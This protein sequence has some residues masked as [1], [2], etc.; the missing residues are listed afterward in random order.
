[1]MKLFQFAI[2]IGSAL[3][4]VGCSDGSQQY[5]DLDNYMAEMKAKPV[6]VIKPLPE[7][8]RYEA[9]TYEASAMRSPFRQPVRIELTP[10]QKNSNLKPDPYRAKQ[11]L[12]QFEMDSFRLV[13]SI[14][15][16]GGILGVITW[17]RRC[18]PSKSR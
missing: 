1:M 5:K 6:G 18:S 9:F 4:L 10:E 14:S 11:Y 16:G 8:N 7:F 3:A 2:V 12:E 15:N 17:E 13:G